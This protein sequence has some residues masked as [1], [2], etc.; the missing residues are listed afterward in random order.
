[1]EKTETHSSFDMSSKHSPHSYA[2]CEVF[3]NINVSSSLLTGLILPRQRK[4]LCPNFKTP[5]YN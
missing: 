5:P 2:S 3:A 4:R 1:M